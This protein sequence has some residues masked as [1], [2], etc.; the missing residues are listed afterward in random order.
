[1]EKKDKK[2][3]IILA[4]LLFV[5]SGVVGYGVYS[6]YWTEGSFSGIGSTIDVAAFDP[7]TTI[8]SDSDF[9][10]HGGTL[11]MTCP[12]STKGNESMS[13]TGSVLITNNGDTGVTIEVFDANS[14]AY[15]LGPEDSTF[16]IE[17]SDPSFSWTSTTISAG[18][19]ATLTITVPFTASSNYGSTEAVEVGEDAKDESSAIGITT[20]F[21]LR[22]TQAH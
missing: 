22:A 2:K 15:N 6:Y 7:Q 19:S 11:H 1:M 4:L 8:D 3:V 5:I 12:D 9:L 18:D 21:K 14:G 13:C 17:T 16:S 20:E 10:G